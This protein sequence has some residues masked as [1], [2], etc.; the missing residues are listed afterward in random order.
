MK[1]PLLSVGNLLGPYMLL[2]PQVTVAKSMPTMLK[3][4]KGPNVTL[5]LLA[6]TLHCTAAAALSD[7]LSGVAFR[8]QQYVLLHLGLYVVYIIVLQT[9]TEAVIGHNSM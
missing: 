4:S 5:C 3:Y 1:C 6:R 9:D 7:A 8:M 2:E